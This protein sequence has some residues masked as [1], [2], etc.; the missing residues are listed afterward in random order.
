MHEHVGAGFELTDGAGFG[1]AL[2]LTGAAGMA[3]VVGGMFVLFLREPGKRFMAAALGFAAGVMV[4]VSFVELLPHGQ[5]EIGFGWAHVAFFA[6]V[7]AMFLIDALVP[8]RYMDDHHDHGLL[9]GTAGSGS[10]AGAKADAERS[11]L[12]RVGLLVALGV[13]IHNF[14]EGMATF[15]AALGSAKLGGAVAIAIAIHNI[16]EGL[17]V[18]APIYAATGSRGRALTW[19][20]VS[21]LAEPAGAAVAGVVLLSFLSPTVLGTMLCVVA[22]LMVYISLDELL[23]ASRAYGHEHLSIAGV[24]LGMAVMALSLGL[25]R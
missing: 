5:G 20:L 19:S 8:H 21:G 18:A 13:G 25:M 16:P 17:A 2:L 23:P 6:G 7:A 12:R 1:V 3:T 11:R 9:V 22:G 10:N 24:V 15:A 4:H 14:P